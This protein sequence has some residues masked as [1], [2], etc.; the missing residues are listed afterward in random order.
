MK[1]KV[2]TEVKYYCKDSKKLIDIAKKLG[3]EEIKHI[4]ENDEYFTD[5]NSEYIKNRT[6][7][8]IRTTNNEKMEITHKGKSN[9]LLGLYCKLENNIKVDI[10]EYEN[11][12]KLF[13]SLGFYSYTN[14]IKD[15]LVYSLENEKYKYSIMIDNL[16]D[17]GG[18]VEFEIITNKEDSNKNELLNELNSFVNKFNELNMEEATKPYRD[19]V[20]DY[21]Y[22]NY[23]KNNDVKKIYINIDSKLKKYENDF[24]NKYKNELEKI[25]GN[26]I[27]YNDFISIKD[28]RI[29]NVIDSYIDNLIFDSNDLLVTISL[30][31]KL[32]FNTTF[33]TRTNELFFNHI[34][35]KLNIDFSNSIYLKDNTYNKYLSSIEE[36]AIIIDEE[37]IKKIN[38]IL[39]IIINHED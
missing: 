35:G 15:R 27:E 5:I 7:L 26:D 1:I 28:T 37:E 33:I 12:V 9:S 36:D 14:V 22:N 3:F 17:I 11:I 39:L 2:E 34:L 32:R 4:S 23:I 16:R 10:N 19:I 6:C 8:R 18:F 25:I 20:A 13:S 24:F 30:L 38:S 21:I 31:N 29:S